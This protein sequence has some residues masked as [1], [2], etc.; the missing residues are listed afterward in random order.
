[1]VDVIGISGLTIAILGAVGTFI[2]TL[3]I[4]E[5]DFCCIHSD[6]MAEARKKYQSTRSGSFTPP[7]TPPS[8]ETPIKTQ[9]D[10]R[11]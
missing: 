5:C 4:R 6:C 1:M 10:G 11:W 3:H 2:N 8:E 7:P 9:P